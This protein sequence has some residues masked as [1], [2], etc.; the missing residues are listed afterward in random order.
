MMLEADIV[1]G[2]LISDPN[3]TIPVMGHPP[4]STSDLSFQDFLNRTYEH[5]N[6]AANVTKK[7]VKLDFKSIEVFEASIN[8]LEQFY[9]KVSKRKNR[10]IRRTIIK[11]STVNILYG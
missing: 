6:N 4:T 2:T 11:A 9:S 10:Y 5:N 8:I 7:G 3:A 1:L